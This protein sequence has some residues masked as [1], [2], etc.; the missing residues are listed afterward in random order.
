MGTVAI[1]ATPGGSGDESWTG[2]IV[3]RDGGPSSLGAAILDEVLTARG[4]LHEAWERISSRRGSRGT[5]SERPPEYGVEWL[6]LLDGRARRL[7]VFAASWDGA[8]CHWGQVTECTF[9]S[10]GIATF[11]RVDEDPTD[12]RNRRAVYNNSGTLLEVEAAMA[13]LANSD[14]VRVPGLAISCPGASSQAMEIRI[15]W[16]DHEGSLKDLAEAR[17]AWVD[18]WTADADHLLFHLQTVFDAWFVLFEQENRIP[19]KFAAGALLAQRLLDLSIPRGEYPQA[20]RTEL[21]RCVVT[22]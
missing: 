11:D 3:Y 20:V 6:Y 22:T 15:A 7:R 13:K 21:L 8:V 16:F 10:N 1:L 4:G 14:L 2:R 19:E 5:T 12:W 9:D 18:R 17:I